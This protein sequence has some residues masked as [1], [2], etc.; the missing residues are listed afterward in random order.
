MI[1]NDREG[2]IQWLKDIAAGKIKKS[3]LIAYKPK[4]HLNLGDKQIYHEKVTEEVYNRPPEP[5]TRFDVTL[6][7]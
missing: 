2:R 6:N 3:D 7:L 1:P 4:I 5:R